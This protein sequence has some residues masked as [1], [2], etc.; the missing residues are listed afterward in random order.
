MDRDDNHTGDGSPLPSLEASVD[1]LYHGLAT[2]SILSDP[3]SSSQEVSADA[4]DGGNISTSAPSDSQPN[5]DSQ[6]LDEF[7]LFPKLIPELRTMIWRHTFPGPRK[8]YIHYG[9]A[10]LYINWNTKQIE[11]FADRGVDS[12]VFPVALQINAGSRAETLRHYTLIHRDN[13]ERFIDFKVY[14]DKKP[15]CINPQIDFA[16]FSFEDFSEKIGASEWWRYLYARYR[17]L[18]TNLKEVEIRNAD[19]A[20]LHE[21]NPVL[22]TAK[23]RPALRTLLQIVLLMPN[24]S[25]LQIHIEPKT[26]VNQPATPEWERGWLKK[27]ILSHLTQLS[28]PPLLNKVSTFNVE[29]QSWEEA[30]EYTNFLSKSDSEKHEMR[31]ILSDSYWLRRRELGIGDDMAINFTA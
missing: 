10:P 4:S 23:M 28:Y 3:S 20:L 5:G 2:G 8:V 7:H 29:I 14:K 24:L 12:A 21:A 9:R 18:L 11:R 6:N 26:S 13:W 25:K 22:Q 1:A 31:Y 15:I 27:N 17:S 30:D 19:L 16:Y